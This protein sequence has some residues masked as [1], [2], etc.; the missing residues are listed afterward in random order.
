MKRKIYLL[1]LAL[2]V[3]LTSIVV[4]KL[5]T[6]DIVQAQASGTP[7]PADLHI[8]KTGAPN[9][10]LAGQPLTYTIVVTNTGPA[11][12]E[13][14]VIKDQL[15]TGVTFNGAWH[16]RMLDGVGA[17][18]VVSNSALTGTVTLLNAG[19]IVTITA[20][21]LVNTGISGASIVNS[22]SVTTTTSLVAGNHTASVTTNLITVTPTS[23]P[24]P[25]PNAADL[26]IS[27]RGAPNPVTAGQPLLYTII[28]TNTGPA[29]AQNVIVKDHLPT[30]VNFNGTS[31]IAVL[32]GLNPQLNLSSNLLTGTV[33]TLNVGG[34][35]TITGRTL[36]NVNTTGASLL[37]TASVTTTND[38][39][40]S[41]NTA[42]VTTNLITPTPTNTPTPTI[43]PTPTPNAADLRISKRSAPNPVAAG[44]ILT[45][46]IVVTNTGPAV[47]QNVIVKDNLPTGVN[48][49]GTSNISVV[50][51]TGS[52][53][54]LTSNTLTGTVGTLNA[55][56]VITIIGRTLVN[57]NVAGASL[58]NTASVTTTNDLNPSN[59]TA[60]ATTNLIT[61]TP[62][63]TPTPTS[64]ST[65]TN[66]ATATAT[67]P[68]TSTPT[69]T[70]TA[71]NTPT[72]T[73]PIPATNTPTS[74]AT[75]GAATATPTNSPPATQTP[76]NTPTP[77][78]PAGT[79]NTPT[80]TAPIPATS[81]PTSTATVV[82]ITATPTNSP[83]ATQT[84]TSTPT[85]TA[86]NTATP[87]NP[88]T[89]LPTTADLRI[90]K[91]SGPNPVTA[92]QILTYTIVVTNVGPSTAQNVLIKDLL[93]AGVSFNGSS[94]INV[95]N[96]A[97]SNLS[98]TAGA[99]TG[100]VGTLNVGGVVTILG[101]T[102]VS[103]NATGTTLLNT[104]N[105]TTTNDVL[106]ANNAAQATTILITSTPT[107]TPSPTPT[108][109][110]TPTP[111][112]T[113]TATLTP[114]PVPNLADLRISKRGAPTL[115]KAGDPLVY[116]IVI[117]NAGPS[118]AQN[119]L[120]QDQLPTGLSFAGGSSIQVK[121]G[122][123]PTLN[124]INSTLTG[125]V[126][127]LNV[128]GVITITGQTLVGLNATGA[129]IQNSASVTTT[130]DNNPNNNT[131]S[132]VVGLTTATP[133]NTPPPTT[134]PIPTATQTP[135]APTPTATLTPTTAQANLQISISS[136]PKQI[137]AGQ[138]LTYTI[139]VTNVGGS[140]ARKVVIKDALPPGVTLQGQT[141]LSLQNG[142]EENLVVES[143]VVTATATVLNA[144]GVMRITVPAHVSPSVTEPALLNT[145]NVNADS[146]S[147]P[148]NGTASVTTLVV[149]PPQGGNTIFL[150]VIMQ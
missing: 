15:P 17:N 147:V 92:G 122:T 82:A 48:F 100:T 24:T 75:T 136:D 74:T 142:T 108:K 6:P 148:L 44:Q 137:V 105:V 91:S 97:N 63:N 66:P 34:V 25:T 55:G 101:R 1:T 131:A 58:L 8:Y 86:T 140:P 35:I 70:P 124:L 123:V 150:P 46:T 49:N 128:G 3:I 129:T 134:T 45:Y 113:S 78:T 2:A 107:N 95:F 90:S 106:P 132:A 79:T 110:P 81:T 111:T 22:A 89:P 61:P 130:T 39:N 103:V 51:G 87:T 67:N 18:V 104:A 84:P 9:P 127:T 138:A 47:A 118:A 96:G 12:A 116:T 117:T 144:G 60:S 29:V 28:V 16:V 139:T 72:A 57:V 69:Q 85:N 98:L 93:P 56:G 145:V 120:I 112:P 37:N 135:A 50:N 149:T 33:G 43:T 77:T 7:V 126:A 143:N 125:T 73:A 14:I 30:G 53:L 52:Q 80:A 23:T 76:T 21:T 10:V 71:T 54:N 65:P 27:K 88:A 4:F 119:V 26:R 20:Q 41:N 40:P 59:N 121:N 38:L 83:A 133:T 11:T 109:T 32:N 94:L 36:V 19:G 68:A 13:N 141:F 146:D 102:L 64:T 114:T 99:L 62:T 42:S 31:A 5:S 115:V